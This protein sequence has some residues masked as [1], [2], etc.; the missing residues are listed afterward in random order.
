MPPLPSKIEPAF[1]GPALDADRVGDAGGM[2]MMKQVERDQATI[3]RA[4]AMPVGRRRPPRVRAQFVGDDGRTAFYIDRADVT[5]VYRLS[6]INTHSRRPSRYAFALEG[7]AGGIGMY[8]DWAARI[9]AAGINLFAPP[10]KHRRPSRYVSAIED[11]DGNAILGIDRDRR[12]AAAFNSVGLARLADDFGT[13]DSW[14]GTEN[15]AFVRMGKQ[16]VRAM[17]T[18]P[19]GTIFDAVQLRYGNLATAVAVGPVE[20][21]IGIGQSNRG[22]GSGNEELATPFQKVDNPH[23]ILALSRPTGVGNTDFYGD[24]T[25]AWPEFSELTPSV[26]RPNYALAPTILHAQARVAVDRRARRRTPA[27]GVIA[28]WRGS[29]PA[30]NFLP[31]AGY[32]LYE[33]AIAG[34]AKLKEN[35]GRYGFAGA[36]C[37][38][39]LW[40]QGEAGPYPYATVFGQ[41][42]DAYVSGVRS[43]LGQSFDPHFYFNQINQ[44]AGDSTA[45]GVE[46]DQRSVA[47]ARLGSVTCTGPM[48]QAEMFPQGATNIHAGNI[49]RMMIADAEAEAAA[50]VEAGGTFRAL[51]LVVTI[52]RTGAQIDITYPNMPGPQ[53][54]VDGD[55]VPDPGSKGFNCFLAAD[56]TPLTIN[57]VGIVGTNVLRL[58][59]SA[60]PGGPVRVDYARDTGAA[61]ALWARG[62]GNL[63]VA[64]GPSSFTAYGTP[65]KVRHYALRMS[66]ITPS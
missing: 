17:L 45:S 39:I 53:L 25:Y 47:V 62:R 46:L 19:D 51:G 4:G 21:V 1:V 23:H 63:Y 60:D 57:G 10:V 65:A 29:Y 61:T 66:E 44:T 18:D 56:G 15:R 35:L 28:S 41:V 27:M 3:I 40:T 26:H 54:L 12:I 30:A 31:G 7:E 2:V 38:R 58:I 8:V 34:I 32:Y 49:G 9:G 43:T 59:L 36:V 50:V 42:I 16:F 14:R 55:I 37:K 5:N 13:V 6:F 24:Q 64:G 22:G 11:Q 48:Y 33:N 20:I 52:A